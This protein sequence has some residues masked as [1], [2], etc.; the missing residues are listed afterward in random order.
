M[1]FS[2][3]PT[4]EAE[5]NNV[6]YSVANVLSGSAATDYTAGKRLPKYTRK[7]RRAIVH[8]FRSDDFPVTVRKNREDWFKLL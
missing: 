8:A 7:V 3:P 2:E 6:L 4:T 5:E 1:I